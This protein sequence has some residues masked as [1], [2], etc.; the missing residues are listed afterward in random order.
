VLVLAEGVWLT[1]PSLAAALPVE[2]REFHEL[3]QLQP[4]KD[5]RMWLGFR[6]R[7]AKR[8]RSDGWAAL[9]RWD[10][11]ATA[12][13]G[14]RWLPPVEMPLSVGRNDMR[15]SSQRDP[16]GSVYFA[17]ASDNRPPNGG[18]PRNSHIAV[19]RLNGMPKSAQAVLRRQERE[20][21]AARLIHPK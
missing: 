11:A 17:Y 12:C 15:I 7:T 5:G 14:D 3:P 21:P 8:P 10:V 16:Q 9:G 13:V 20:M 19:S 2:M 4:D 6:Y 1:P 18:T